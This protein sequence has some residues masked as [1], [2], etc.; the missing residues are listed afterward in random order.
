MAQVLSLA[1]LRVGQEAYQLSGV[2]Q[3][4]DDYYS[5]A[6]EAAGRWIGQG[7]ARL[8]LVGEVD[9][10]DLR[11]VLAG[12]APGTGGLTPDGRTINPHPRRVPGFDA[13]FKVPKSASVLYAV[14]DDPRVQ[15]AIVE[16]GDA[17]V[18]DAIGWLERE[19]IKVRR[20]TA[21][22]A[23]L[24]SLAARDP[25]AADRARI[26]ALPA[27]G[28]SAAAFRHRTSRA[29]DPL[30]H[31]HVLIANLVEG[32]DGR[33][34][35]FVHPDLFRAAKA[36][37]EVFQA[38]FR[39][40]LT[41]RLGVQWRPGRHVPEVVGVPDQLCDAFSKRSRE[42]EDWLAATGTPD[43][44]GGRQAAVL[45]TRRNKA[46]HEDERFDA[47]WKAEAA[48]LGWG[49]DAAEALIS[50]AADRLGDSDPEVWRIVRTRHAAT[51]EMEVGEATVSS[52]EWIG[53]LAQ[54][55]TAHDS[56]FDRI[57]VVEAVAR[58]LGIGAR[59]SMV[60]RVVAKV[61]ASDDVTRIGSDRWS[62][63]E[64]M[65][66]EERLLAEARLSQSTLSP[67]WDESSQQLIEVSD[68][69]A[70]QVAV[71]RSLATSR[72]GIS[73]LV[74]QAGTGKTHALAVLAAVV[75]SSGGSIH[76][77]A[78]SARAAE[79]L[80]K[81]ASI[82]ARTIHRQRAAWARG[83]GVPLPTDVWVVDEAAMTSTRDLEAVVTAVL[84]AGARVVLVGDHHQLPEVGPG[85]GFAGLMRSGTV[86]VAEL[87]ENRR[88]RHAWE[89]EALTHVRE[90]RAS[91][92]VAAYEAHDRIAVS[93]DRTTMVDAAVRRWLED[94]D[95]SILLAGTNEMVRALNDSARAAL[96][97][98][99]GLG[100]PVGFSGGRSFSVGDR[101]VARQNDYDAA[102]TTGEPTH[103][104]NGQTGTVT[105][106]L[107]AGWLEVRMDRSDLL[108]AVAPTYLAEGGLDHAYALTAHRAQG[109]TWDIAIS[110]G[111]DGLH[112]EA[113]YLLLSRGRE[114]NWLHLTEEEAHDLDEVLARHDSAIPLPGEDTADPMSDLHRRLSTS[115][116]KALAIDLDPLA[117]AATDVVSH[118]DLAV[119]ES[120]ASSAR[121]SE[122]RATRPGSSAPTLTPI[123][124]FGTGSSTRP[125]TSHR[126]RPSERSTATT[127]GRSSASMTDA[128]WRQW[129]SLRPMA[130]TPNGTW[131]GA[132]S[133]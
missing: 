19:V 46:E 123:A 100:P 71:V 8:G 77:L 132:P 29:G 93:A 112:R 53:S 20:G 128:A 40:E 73:L 106:A 13:T 102:T 47:V 122:Q 54:E 31:W 114:S 108:V 117:R 52:G 76:G 99:G 70:D 25:E 27:Q 83:D 38:S 3:S 28:I 34:S 15:G 63:T 36:A 5:G 75:E 107:G 48:D 119:L 59:S 80:S 22:E 110:V 55:L 18:E 79:E 24:T 125:D 126:A 6:R 17:A 50:D 12:M 1:K 78:P 9:P 41:L 118:L 58:R 105:D 111:I 60:E 2:A 116:A 67:C 23:F 57:D 69:G 37:G 98:A 42:I 120:R 56:T 35:A 127:S 90:G 33:W 21:N 130:A 51:G 87:T 88:Q 74:G 103:L 10:D 68:L 92:A 121:Q 7:A 84:D 113:G 104:L 65:A 26:R 124:G 16:A 61:L 89:R 49:P 95:R 133:R 81:G 45:A 96:T 43:D 94:P 109:G 91:A 44:P 66:A 30:L 82:E 11:A 129:P 115:R 62:S 85:G 97:E 4:L 14:S 101:V 64:L 39:D 32:P 86:T 72:D 131:R